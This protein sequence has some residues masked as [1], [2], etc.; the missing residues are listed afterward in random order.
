[1]QI[2][3]SNKYSNIYRF[4]L[5]SGGICI[6]FPPAFILCLFALIAFYWEDKYLLVRRYVVAHRL[7]FRLTEKLQK[8]M[9]GFPVMMATTNLIVMFVPIQDG[10]A[11]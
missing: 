5:F 2:D 7:N 6:I 11:F 10:K 9:W 8:I 1:M 3:L 4:V